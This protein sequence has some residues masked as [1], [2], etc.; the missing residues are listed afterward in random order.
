[1][2]AYFSETDFP[3]IQLSEG[4]KEQILKAASRLFH[5]RGYA[6]T[7]MRLLAAEMNIE[8]ASLY[9]HIASKQDILRELLFEMAAIFTSEMKRVEASG[10]SPL[11]KLEKLILLHI[12]L[13]YSQPDALALIVGEWVHLEEP[14]LQ[15]FIKLRNEYELGFKAV[16]NEGIVLGQ[17]K[18]TEPET[19]LFTLLSTLHALPNWLERHKNFDP[20]KLSSDLLQN[21]LFGL[22]KP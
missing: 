2:A 3:G 21:L 12:Y 14:A 5:K 13:A 8:A 1:L 4:R 17:F 7:T 18:Q 19:A 9:N 10:L 15:Q 11:Q 16:L 20:E 22:V 6:A